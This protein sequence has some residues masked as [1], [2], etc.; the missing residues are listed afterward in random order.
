MLFTT[1]VKVVLAEDRSH[2]LANVKVSLFDRDT[3]SRD[4]LLGTGTTDAHG[5][6]EFQYHSE[7][8]QDV[9]DR[10]RESFP[11][12]YAVV[13]GAEGSEQVATTRDHAQGNYVRR[14]I[15]VAVPREDAARHNLLAD[16][17]APA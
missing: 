7:D 6:V 14:V 16:E 2:G 3:F 15:T 5:E 10:M 17:A 12:L 1:T 4:D 13:H 11:E 8:F 9:E